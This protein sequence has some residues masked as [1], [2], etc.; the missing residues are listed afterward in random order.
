VTKLLIAGSNKMGDTGRPWIVEQIV[1]FAK[2]HKCTEGDH[3]RFVLLSGTSMQNCVFCCRGTLRTELQNPTWH[4]VDVSKSR[5]VGAA[6]GQRRRAVAYST[7]AWILWDGR[8]RGTAELIDM[9]E[10][11]GIPFAVHIMD[12]KVIATM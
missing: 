6:A 5:G 11:K 9:V 1:E 8:S 12:P 7:H 10:R 3:N 4:A 2:K